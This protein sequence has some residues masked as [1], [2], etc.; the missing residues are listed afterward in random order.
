[1]GYTA[2]CMCTLWLSVIGIVACYAVIW[3]N[4]RAIT[5]RAA[6]LLSGQQQ[7]ALVHREET[8]AAKRMYVR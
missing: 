8:A 4:V 5:R 2:L 1:M 7:S 6:P 3:R